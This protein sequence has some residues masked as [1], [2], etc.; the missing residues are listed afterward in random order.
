MTEDNKDNSNNNSLLQ[1]KPDDLKRRIDKGEDIFILDVRNP[2]EHKSWKVSYDKY[3][4][5]S[6]IPIDALSSPDALNQIPKD[7]EIVT[8]CGHGIRSKGAAK[9]L[10]GMGYNV[11]SIE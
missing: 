10:S 4:D 9:I 7:K 2:E 6:V 11:K 5:S 1:I 3:Q 8:F